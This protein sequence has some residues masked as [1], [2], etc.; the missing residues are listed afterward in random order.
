MAI[1]Q[2]PAIVAKYGTDN[3]YDLAPRAKIFRRD[4]D[5]VVDM[6]S[7]QAIMRQNNYKT[8]P[9][10]QGDPTAAICARGDLQGGT[11]EK[12]SAG[13]CYDSKVTDY[14]SALSMRSWAING[15]TTGLTLPP[16]SWE[17]FPQLSHEGLPPV[18][19]FSFEEE[20]PQW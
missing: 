2:D 13:G 19:N 1:F 20:D 14:Y 7:F 17:Q 18:Y 11:H 4:Q 8:D 3:S 15:P 12:P 10:S 5:T 16:F 6:P 9:Y